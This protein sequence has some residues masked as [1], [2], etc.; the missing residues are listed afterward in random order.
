MTIKHNKLDFLF[1]G[2]SYIVVSLN[3]AI[4]HFK[5]TTAARKHLTTIKITILQDLESSFINVFF[6]NVKQE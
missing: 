4:N 2:Q 6:S 3:R 5:A 1:C